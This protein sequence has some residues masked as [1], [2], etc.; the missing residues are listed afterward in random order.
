MKFIKRIFKWLF[1]K[2][3]LS[4]REKLSIRKTTEHPF[5]YPKHPQFNGNF[6]ANMRDGLNI[7]DYLN[8]D[9]KIDWDSLRKDS[10]KILDYQ[11]SRYY[12][13]YD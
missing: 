12:D 11:F 5:I 7:Y 9:G 8:D 6:C 4:I 2:K 1:D 3:D 10:D 13:N